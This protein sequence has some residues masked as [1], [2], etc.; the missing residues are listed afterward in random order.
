MRKINSNK[1]EPTAGSGTLSETA[2]KTKL[3]VT[4]K[5]VRDSTVG[6]DNAH[7]S[8]ARGGTSGLRN[9]SCN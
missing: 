7:P 3:F 4:E 9:S 2:S 5:V 1:R 6:V 8:P